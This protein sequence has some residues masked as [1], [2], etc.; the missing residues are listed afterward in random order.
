MRIKDFRIACKTNEALSFLKEFGESA[1]LI[2]GGTSTYFIKSK[3]PRIAIDINRIPN[4]EI[5]KEKNFF[6]IGAGASINDLLKYSGDGW[7]LNKVARYFVNQQFRN[8]STIGGNISRVFY[9]SD[10][11]VV[12]R[13]FE[14]KLLLTGEKTNKIKIEDAF[15]NIT[16]HK[17]FFKDTILELIEIP[18]L[19]KGEGFGYFKETRTS[20]A[21][22][23]A[24]VAAYIKIE[25][26]QISD[27]K[28][29]IGA[30]L[31]FPMR[32]FEIEKILIGKN[33]DIG[34]LKYVDFNLL[35]KY[36]IIPR[37][38]M[39]LDYCIHLLKTRICDVLS[40][41]IDDAVKR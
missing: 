12:L 2:A 16:R 6:R 7:V 21:F 22:S 33:A 31:P 36:K 5:K 11:P 37:E 24:T 39:S 29:S 8:I 18:A 13:I 1:F 28:I 32:L 3:I 19:G 26:K 23:S 34:S 17:R 4:K 25:N 15:Y 20:Q 38:N 10:F 14:G 40:E 27:L 30:V 41:A 35:N 9:W